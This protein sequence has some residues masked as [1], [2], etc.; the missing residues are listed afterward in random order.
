M[1]FG[2]GSE[3]KIESEENISEDEEI[4]E[5]LERYINAV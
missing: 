3:A 5:E 1:T 2:H 4:S